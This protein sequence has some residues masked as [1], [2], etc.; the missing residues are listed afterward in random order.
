MDG[1]LFFARSV[2][3]TQLG[4]A[5]SDA[6]ART[7]KNLERLEAHR[8]ESMGRVPVEARTLA[9]LIFE[10]HATHYRAERDWLIRAL[11]ALGKSEAYE[12]E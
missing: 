11:D 10:H 4:A 12:E 1:A 8:S 2:T 6:L 5:I 3:G 9:D 7:E